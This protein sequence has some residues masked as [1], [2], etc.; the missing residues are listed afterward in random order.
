MLPQRQKHRRVHVWALVPPPPGGVPNPGRSGKDCDAF[1][2]RAGV[3]H[4]AITG[5]VD[6]GNKLRIELTATRRPSK[7]LGSATSRGNCGPVRRAA[8]G[9]QRAMEI[10]AATLVV[11]FLDPIRAL[12]V[13]GLLFASRKAWAI[14]FAAVVSAVAT[15]TV[16]TMV[17][18]TRTWGSGLAVSF[19]A[20]LLQAAV[21]SPLVGVIRRRRIPTEAKSRA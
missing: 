7:L 1:A 14:L 9:Q 12:I 15:E 16:L 13:F 20:S 3:I 10:L 21:L 6:S 19:I 2:A 8:A 11:S 5:P 18:V 17:L 4:N